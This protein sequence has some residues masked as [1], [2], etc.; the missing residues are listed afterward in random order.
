[1]IDI[2]DV[3]K[4]FK[5]IYTYNLD[6]W[7]HNTLVK[8]NLITYNDKTDKW[9]MSENIGQHMS[10]LKQVISVFLYDEFRYTNNSIF[11]VATKNKKARLYIRLLLG[12]PDTTK[13]I[14]WINL[15]WIFL[16]EY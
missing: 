11:Y 13:E 15:P 16:Q 4:W 6:V 1:M 5:N 12:P 10:S 3:K 7:D 2:L 14:T 9:S 8:K